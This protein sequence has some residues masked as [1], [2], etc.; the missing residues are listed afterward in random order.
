LAKPESRYPALQHGLTPSIA[1]SQSITFVL[2]DFGEIEDISLN[3]FDTSVSLFTEGSSS[4][5]MTRFAGQK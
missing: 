4:T 2:T 3:L 1:E 5:A